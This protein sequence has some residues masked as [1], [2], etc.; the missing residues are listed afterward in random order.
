MINLMINMSK[1]KAITGVCKIS[2]EEFCLNEMNN[3]GY[4]NLHWNKFQKMKRYVNNQLN[5]RF[6]LRDYREVHGFPSPKKNPL[7]SEDV[8]KLEVWAASKVI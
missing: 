1:E 6:G 4:S 3:L 5:R 7:P 8:Q 2:G